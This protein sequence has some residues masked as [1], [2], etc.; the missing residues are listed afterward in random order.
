MRDRSIVSYLK[1]AVASLCFAL[2]SAEAGPRFLE[3]TPTAFAPLPEQFPFASDVA[4]DGN[5]LAVATFQI[6]GLQRN[7]YIYERAANGVWGTPTL[8]MVG[9]GPYHSVPVHIA[10]QGNVLAMTFRNQLQIAERT[11]S[12]WVHTTTLNTPPGITEMGAD[13]DI[14]AGTIVVG[15]ESSR[16]QALIY[17][18]SASGVWQYNGHVDGET[19]VPGPYEDFFGGNVDIS[20]NT[21]MVGSV[22]FTAPGAQPQPRAFAFTNING[23][24]VQSG[25]F[26]YPLQP[27]EPHGFAAGVAID[28]DSIVLTQGPTLHLYRRAGGTWSYASSV[29]P[30][31]VA[32]GPQLPSPAMSGDLVV[33]A[34]ASG[35][36]EAMYLYQRIGSQLNLAAKLSGR[37][38]RFDIAGRAVIGAEADDLTLFQVPVDLSVPP[39]RQDNFQDGNAAG[40]APF[41]TTAWSVATA[42]NTLVYRQS[43]LASESRAIFN[44]T[45][46]TQQSVQADIKPTAFDG[47]DRW[48]GLATRYIDSSN[49][50]YATLRNSNTMLLRKM[51]NGSFQTL[52]TRTLSIV[53][54]QTYRVRLEAVGPRISVSVNEETALG[55]IDTSLTHGQAALLTYRTRADVDNVIVSPNPFLALFADGFYA[56]EPPYAPPSPSHWIETGTGVWAGP[57]EEP[58]DPDYPDQYAHLRNYRQTSLNG[59]ARSHVGVSTADQNVQTRVVPT[60]MAASGWFGVMARY[61]DDANYYYL[62]LGNGEASIRKLVNGAIVELARVSFTPSVNTSYTVRLE[63][64]ATSL[65]AYINNRFVLEAADSSHAAGKY[66]VVTYR[67]TATFDDFVVTQP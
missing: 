3:P 55:A 56:A 16:A 65:R 64:V 19:F 50:Y 57:P 15:A 45:D 66:G 41:P 32:V 36:P 52:G 8:V 40:W 9:T 59:G 49:Y 33:Q 12:G 10:L 44:G 46:W 62:K 17:R 7:V 2:G 21:I 1:L 58:A 5:R 37:F 54:N 38:S 20:D 48:F 67:A 34:M 23:T 61:I 24:W 53:P 29:R 18:K 4:F 42:T 26:A 22:G 51:V 11:A 13:V 43:N 28:G 27:P 25:A 60:A 31:E 35:D 39:L 6:Q 30:P 14:D 47:T 63:A